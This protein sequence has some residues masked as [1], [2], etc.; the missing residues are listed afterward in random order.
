M[1][2]I[3]KRDELWAP[4]PVGRIPDA[5]RERTESVRFGRAFLLGAAL[6]TPFWVIVA[7]ALAAVR[8]FQ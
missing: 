2:Q 6:A 4:M 7:A 8:A 3:D 5:Q 1:D